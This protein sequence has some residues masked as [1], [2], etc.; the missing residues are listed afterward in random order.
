MLH[1]YIIYGTGEPSPLS[2]RL[3]AAALC[4]A[5]EEKP[6]GTCRDC[7]K[8]ARGVHPD[9]TNVTLL[10]DAR[11]ITVEQARDLCSD[12][13][14]APSES[15]A[16]V[17]IVHPADLMN[18]QAQNALLKLLEEPPPHVN[19]LLLAQSPDA[20]LETVRS[21]CVELYERDE[22]EADAPSE[23]TMQLAH[24]FWTAADEGA[25]ALTEFSF[26]LDKLERAEWTPFLIAAKSVAAQRLREG[27]GKLSAE[28][29]FRAVDALTRAEEYLAMSVNGTHMAAM[30]CAEI[31][32]NGR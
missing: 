11:I 1:A 20:L 23:E 18:P 25:L 7:R 16:K 32:V 9:V 10:K 8:V 14:V 26:K 17:Y 30:I 12:A 2:E 3:T 27:A 29:T 31:T 21:R 13:L 6:C 22:T 5:W 28:M 4:S 24:A 19:L 15:D